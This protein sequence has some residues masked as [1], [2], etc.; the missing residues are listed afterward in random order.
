MTKPSTAD[1]DRQYQAPASSATGAADGALANL[2]DSC[3][4]QAAACE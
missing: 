3:V 4:Y 1:F 2:G